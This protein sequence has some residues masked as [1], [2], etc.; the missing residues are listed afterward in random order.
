[1]TDTKVCIVSTSDPVEP[2]PGGIDAFIRGII[3]HAPEDIRFELIG[4]ST[5]GERRPAKQWHECQ[6]ANTPVRFFP[7]LTLNKVGKQ[8]RIPVSLRFA[9]K[10]ITGLPTLNCDVL[11]FHRFELTLP[12]L[13]RGIPMNAFAHQ[14]MNVIKD[15][16]SDIRWKHAPGLYFWLEDRTVP[17]LSS[18]FTVRED[19]AID[20]RNRYPQIASWIKFTPT[21]YDPARFYCLDGEDRK[22]CQSELRV[23]FGFEAHDPI[24]ISVG[25]LD[26]QKDPLLLLESFAVLLH[27][28]PNA[29]LVLVGDGILK[30]ELK[31]RIEQLGLTNKAVLAGLRPPHQICRYLNG[32]DVF[33]LSSVYEGM[34]IALLEAGA[35]GV[36]LVSTDAGEAKRVI[37][38]DNGLLIHDRSPESLG[39][40]LKDCLKL[41]L[42]NSR[43]ARSVLPFTP[44][45][46]LQPIYE[47]YRRL[48]AV[49]PT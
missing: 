17:K 3:A 38:P 33:C 18:L 10:L 42:D 8:S 1:M 20:Y 23:E 47:N 49:T 19:A 11:D 28:V 32:A 30:E 48:A 21:W 14:N 7:L 45:K 46:V 9:L 31:Q 36:P 5:N 12:F 35:C 2:V 29:K 44:E 37:S 41:D 16:S 13:R 34:P 15:G 22:Q 27:S 4:V 39:A 26:H 40:A 43:I 6:V 25:R 24:V